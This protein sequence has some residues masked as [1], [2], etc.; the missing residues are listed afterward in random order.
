VSVDNG[1]PFAPE[2]AVEDLDADPVL[3]AKYIEFCSAQLTEVFLSL[4][5][6]RIYDLVEE[7]A[8]DED[9]EPGSLGFRA[10]V[11][12]VTRRLR[13][14]VPLPDFGTWSRDY[15]ADPEQYDRY[16]LGL[17]RELAANQSGEGG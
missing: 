9:L 8:I 6:E 1:R 5:D 16:L 12:L 14:S 13:S 10:M 15:E 2:L 4:S 7:A 3:K 17:W 11:R